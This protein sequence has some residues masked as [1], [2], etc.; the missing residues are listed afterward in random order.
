MELSKLSLGELKRLKSRIETEIGRRTD[1][2]KRDLLKKFQKMTAELGLSINDVIGKPASNPDAPKRG[3][4]AGAKKAGAP[5]AKVAPKYRNPA[6]DTQ[7]WTGRG[8][9]P[10]WV[11][12]QLDQG[13][14]LDD[15]LIK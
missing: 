11:A 6:D 2:T 8:R 4:K 3:P 15:L 7:T 5:R 12:Q 1:T 10:Q 14:S 9:K 13:K